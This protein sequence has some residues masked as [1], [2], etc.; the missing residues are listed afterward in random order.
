MIDTL[1]FYNYLISKKLDTF[2]GVPDSLL[3]DICACITKNS[4]KEKHIITANEGNAIGLAAGKYLATKIPAVVYLQ[5]SGLGNTANPLI[6]L[7]DEDVYKIPMLLLVGWR[8]EPNTKDEPQHVKQGKITLEMLEVMGIKHIILT[9][10]FK[11]Q[12]D[13]AYNYMMETSKTIALIVKKNT[14]SKFSFEKNKNVFSLTREKAL[15]TILTKISKESLIVS[16]T[17][18]TSREVFEIREKNSD[19]H[20]RDFLTVGSMGHTSSIALG[21]SLS[22]NKKVYCIDGDGSLL[23]HLGSLAITS[24][25]AK[26]NYKY[27]VINNGAHESVGGQPTVA[28]DLDFK[29]I[30]VGLGFKHFFEVSSTEEIN[31]KFD[32]FD[33]SE[34]AVMVVNVKEGS[35]DDLGRPTTSPQEN[36]KQLMEFI[37]KSKVE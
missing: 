15:E 31:Q 30:F 11:E 29:N 6:S 32:L 36:K 5:N 9:D 8:G 2:Y 3:K 13:Y 27:I 7:A 28:F 20:E 14:F 37:S 33:S 17:G 18:K 4:I 1:E 23:M 22:T 25:N 24:K 34:L 16:T 26:S 19:S 12:I 21:I 35:R 10:D